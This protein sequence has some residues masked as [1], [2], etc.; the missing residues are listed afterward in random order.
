MIILGLNAFHGDSAAAL[1]PRRQ[2][3]R[4][5]GGGAL[6][7]HQALG[8]LSRRRRSPIACARRALRWPTSTTSR[9]IRTAAPT[10]SA[11]A[12]ATCCAPA[13]RSRASCCSGC[14]DRRAR[15]RCG[16]PD[17][18]AERMRRRAF[19]RQ[20]H[21]IEHHRAHLCLRAFHVSPF[22]AGGR[23]VSVDG[24]GDF[25]SAAWGVG[26]GRRHRRRRPRLFSR[27]RSASSIRR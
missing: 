20:V 17:L 6:P 13:A 12:R 4:C 11:K 8:R 1:D 15:R 16:A 25:A 3:R 2:A 5:R 10:S 14:A 19:R 18:L 23:V 22:T 24:F 27:I 7:P 26:R 9:S 21:P